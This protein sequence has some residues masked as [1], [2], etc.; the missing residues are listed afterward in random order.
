M[1]LAIADKRRVDH[2]ES[3]QVTELIGS[4]DGRPVLIVDD[5]ASSAGTLV[6]A[7]RALVERG[8]SAVYAAVTHGLLGPPAAERLN[9]SPIRTLF[10]TDTVEH[11]PAPLPD[12][13]E[14]VSVAELFGEAIRRIANRESISVLFG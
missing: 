8:A 6:D 3:A 14:V 9:A 1:P 13:V 4:V 10:I 11:R 5:F 7:A 12:N 2:S